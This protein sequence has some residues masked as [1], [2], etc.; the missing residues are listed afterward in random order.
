MVRPRASA[1]LAS[2]V[3]S[4]RRG[5]F[6]AY[7]T[8]P[9]A[10]ILRRSALAAVRFVRCGLRVVASFSRAPREGRALFAK[11]APGFFGSKAPSV[12]AF[13]AAAEGDLLKREDLRHE[14]YA[15][16]DVAL[17]EHAL[18][19]AAVE[20]ELGGAEVRESSG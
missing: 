13:V 12:Q 7:S 10:A 2:C 5:A 20:D 16:P 4:A 6:P 3:P 11:L 8:S 17:L 1:I 18:A 15:E 19:V 9:G 14:A